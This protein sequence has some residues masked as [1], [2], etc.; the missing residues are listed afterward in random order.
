MNT[1]KEAELYLLNLAILLVVCVEYVLYPDRDDEEYKE[2]YRLKKPK[3]I[4]AYNNL[5]DLPKENIPNED[6]LEKAKK[7]FYCEKFLDEDG[8]LN[9]IRSY[10]E[11][12]CNK[13]PREKEY[14]KR[15]SIEMMKDIHDLGK[16][17]FLRCA[18]RHRNYRN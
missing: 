18:E 16:L 10:L 9:N 12:E 11:Y 4:E 2:L 8:Y 7:F 15:S 17:G 6:Q 3:V 5:H 1:W 14:I 13:G